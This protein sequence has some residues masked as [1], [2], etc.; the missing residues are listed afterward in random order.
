[1]FNVLDHFN[2]IIEFNCKNCDNYNKIDFNDFA[3][4]EDF[5]SSSTERNMGPEVQHN[6]LSIIECSNCKEEHDL[7][8]I[9]VEY[10]IGAFNYENIEI[11]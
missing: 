10:P 7:E 8:I 5:D 6:F 2:N 11:R 1:M 9:V 4:I 3:T